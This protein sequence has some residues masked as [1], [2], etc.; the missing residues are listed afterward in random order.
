MLGSESALGAL[1]LRISH[2]VIP[3][4]DCALMGSEP[5]SSVETCVSGHNTIGTN[6][7]LFLFRTKICSIIS[8][9]H[10]RPLL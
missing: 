4:I 9:F 2:L 5:F 3:A 7:Q 8:Y 6:Q 10:I 1:C